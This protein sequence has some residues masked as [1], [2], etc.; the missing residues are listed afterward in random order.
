M[1][2]LK[3]KKQPNLKKLKFN[4]GD[5][6]KV[7]ENSNFIEKTEKN[8]LVYN[9]YKNRVGVIKNIQSRIHNS[10]TYLVEMMSKNGL[11]FT[12]DILEK[13][14]EKCDIS[15]FTID[16]IVMINDNANF[17]EKNEENKKSYETYKKREGKII[18]IKNQSP[19]KDNTTFIVEMLSAKNTTFRFDI[20]GKYLIKIDK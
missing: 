11:L 6:I 19:Y 9:T 12:F 4:I 17:I 1:N 2:N 8:K 18:E 20:L 5:N 7:L 14:L 15:E 10:V 13:Y 16:D 3:I